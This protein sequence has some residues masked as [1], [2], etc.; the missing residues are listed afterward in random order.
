MIILVYVYDFALHDLIT[1]LDIVF[2]KTCAYTCTT[3][4]SQIDYYMFVLKCS[5]VPIRCTSIA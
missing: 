3:S 5:F 2:M 1:C 4:E